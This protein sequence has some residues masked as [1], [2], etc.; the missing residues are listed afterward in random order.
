MSVERYEGFRVRRDR[1]GDTLLIDGYS[2]AVF[3]TQSEARRAALDDG[4]TIDGSTSKCVDCSH[5]ENES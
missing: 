5:Q 2:F 4:W 1:Y 3:D